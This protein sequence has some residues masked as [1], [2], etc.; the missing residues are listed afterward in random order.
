MFAEE[1]V[2]LVRLLLD[3]GMMILI[4]LVQ[5][6]IYPF[7]LYVR[8]SEFQR[9]H[10]KYTGLISLFVCPL[11][12]G[13]LAVYGYALWQFG[14]WQHYLGIVFIVIA[15]G[16]TFWLSVPCHDRMQK[17]GF[18]REVIMRLIRTNWIRTAAWTA[19]LLIDCGT[20]LSGYTY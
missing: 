3:F 13:Q 2:D 16:A 20:M 14:L 10:Y 15:W 9:W 7:F 17:V 4:W 18:E 6:I 5:L 19:M 8:E 1:V 11:M 12:F